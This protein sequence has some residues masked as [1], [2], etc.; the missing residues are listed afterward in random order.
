MAAFD[1]AAQAVHHHLLAIADAQD[2]HAQPEHRSGGIGAP[3]AKTEAGPPEK[4]TAFGAK[5]ARKRVVHPVEGVDFAI[6]VQLAQAARDQLRHLAAEV[7]DEKAVMRGV[8]RPRSRCAV[9]ARG[10]GVARATPGVFG[11]KKGRMC[12]FANSAHVVLGGKRR[13]RG[14][15]FGRGC[16]ISGPQGLREGGEND[17]RRPI[18]QW[19]GRAQ[20]RGGGGSARRAERTAVSLDTAQASSSATSRI[21]RS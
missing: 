10:R 19:P 18:L 3:S 8:M 16:G 14:A 15:G 11:P 13:I 6:D 1:L 2:R 4:I 12:R 7:D 21:S 17:E 20:A 9:F 5:A